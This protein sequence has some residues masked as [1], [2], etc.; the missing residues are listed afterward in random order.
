MLESF[1]LRDIDRQFSSIFPT[2]KSG[3]RWTNL[4]RQ[5]HHTA[6][7]KTYSNWIN[8]FFPSKTSLK[9]DLRKGTFFIFFSSNFPPLALPFEQ[10]EASFD[11]GWRQKFA[12]GQRRYCA[13]LRGAIDSDLPSPEALQSVSESRSRGKRKWQGVDSMWD[14][15]QFEMKS[16]FP[17]GFER[18]RGWSGCLTQIR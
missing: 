12:M 3:S 4:L 1:S 14:V 15:L 17:K 2:W 7:P 13:A 10:N 8:T 11:I 18:L 6:T 16:R 9:N 5:I